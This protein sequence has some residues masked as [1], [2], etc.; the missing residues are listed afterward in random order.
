LEREVF[1]DWGGLVAP[2]HPQ[3]Q[4]WFAAVSDP[5]GEGFVEPDLRLAVGDRFTRGFHSY[6]LAL[7]L[8]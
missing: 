1:A 3:F 5:V 2:G 7:D 8:L 6:Q 4:L